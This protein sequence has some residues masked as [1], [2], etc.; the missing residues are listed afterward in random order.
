M[1]MFFNN[2]RKEKKA[3]PIPKGIWIT[4]KN[5]VVTLV[6]SGIHCPM[7]PAL[8][9]EVSKDLV[10]FANLADSI[11]PREVEHANSKT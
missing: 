8:A 11:E 4:A 3:L 7:T 5:G 1:I 10:R 2:L 6:H 9:R